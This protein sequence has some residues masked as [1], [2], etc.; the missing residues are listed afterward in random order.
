M[1][2]ET[3]SEKVAEAR[4][5]LKTP[6]DHRDSAVIAACRTVETFSASANEIAMARE[7]RLVRSRS[8][9]AA[10]AT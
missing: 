1:V 2:C 5:V 9:P 7:L 4:L 6:F 10:S 8:V 3:I